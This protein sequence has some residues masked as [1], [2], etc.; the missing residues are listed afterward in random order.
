MVLTGP[1]QRNLEVPRILS[2]PDRRS[3]TG[4]SLATK[5]RPKTDPLILKKQNSEC[6]SQARL[7][8]CMC[9]CFV[10]QSET[11]ALDLSVTG[12]RLKSLLIKMRAVISFHNEVRRPVEVQKEHRDAGL[13]PLGCATLPTGYNGHLQLEGA[14]LSGSE[15]ACRPFTVHAL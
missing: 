1:F 12:R 3:V 7:N 4:W 13:S 8:E 10:K 5:H 2:L 15:S 9:T 14:R 11:K 6:R